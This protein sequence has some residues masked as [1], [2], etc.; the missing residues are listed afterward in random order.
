MTALYSLSAA[1]AAQRLGLAPGVAP[2]DSTSCQVDGRSNSDEEPEEHVMHIPR[3]YSRDQR[4]DL[5][6]VMLDWIVAPQ[7]GIP[8][9]MQPLS[10]H[11]SDAP[12]F[13][14]IITDPIAQLQSTYGTTFLVADSALYRAEKLQ[15]LAETRTQWI[16]RV[17][18][19]LSA[20]QAV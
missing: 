2:L 15:Q 7:A 16:T 13:G 19:T 3:G 9:L 4:P 6:P 10:G 20:A 17:P 1:T 8:V 18:A 11:R 14:Q 5:N 12:D